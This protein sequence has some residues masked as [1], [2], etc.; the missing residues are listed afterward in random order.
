M[1][2][3]EERLR[4]AGD[5]W[6]SSGGICPDNWLFDKSRRIREGNEPRAEGIEP[7][8]SFLESTNAYRDVHE[9]ITGGSSPERWLPSRESQ[10]S[11]ERLVNSTGTVPE[12]RLLLA[13]NTSNC[14]EA[15]KLGEIRPEILL[16]VDPIL[17]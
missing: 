8:K 14:C 10:L 11:R 17:M 4:K 6:P 3:L 13:S 16:F 15:P 5:K 1:S 9:L 12:R 2:L 7:V